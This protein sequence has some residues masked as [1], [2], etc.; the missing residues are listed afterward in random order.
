ML[1]KTLGKQS[2]G[3]EHQRRGPM[4]WLG[5]ELKIRCLNLGTV[6]LKVFGQGSLGC[7]LANLEVPGDSN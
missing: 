3:M 1:R 7:F 5:D 6:V 4:K 2:K